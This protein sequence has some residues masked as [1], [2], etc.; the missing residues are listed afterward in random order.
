MSSSAFHCLPRVLVA[1]ALA[2]LAGCQ[3]LPEREITEPAPPALQPQAAEPD[4]PTRLVDAMD[5]LQNGQ[6]D[7]AADMLESLRQQS[8]G[9]PILALLLRQLNESPEALLPPPYRTLRVEPGDTLS[10]L[11]ERELGNPLLFVALARLNE[12][13]QPKRL[14]VGA[15]LR[16]PDRKP[17]IAGGGSDDSA[18]RSTADD[19]A[20]AVNDVTGDSKDDSRAQAQDAAPAD[21]SMDAAAGN[22]SRRSELETVAEYL[23]ASG[24]PTDARELLIAA[25]REQSL[26][27]GAEE[28]LV[29]LS[30]DSA[31]AEV[32][33]DQ[34]A[35]ATATLAE[36]MTVL[37]PGPLRARLE[38]QRTRLAVDERLARAEAFEQRGLLLEAYR[39]AEQALALDDDHGLA[40]QREAA[41]REALVADYHDRALRAWRARDIDLAIRTWDVLLEAVPTFEP[42]RVYLE[43]AR[44]LRRRLDDPE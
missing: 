23:L 20:D 37:G 8:P 11:A 22:G 31:R 19:R 24:Q 1:V 4:R 41:L 6:F 39:E 13:R 9:S 12:L 32:E 30:L 42:A 35:T 18:G 36:A 38:V 15:E 3:V 25:G 28:L 17:A 27:D 21:E 7:A 26:S 2:L 43:R 14:Q 33:N 29:E 5:A 44:R 34:F 16:V 40:I 10:E